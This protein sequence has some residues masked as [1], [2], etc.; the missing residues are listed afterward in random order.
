MNLLQKSRH[1]TQFIDYSHEFKYERFFESSPF[2]EAEYLYRDAQ[3][4]KI[5]DATLPQEKVIQT[6]GPFYFQDHLVGVF[7]YE[8]KVI[9]FSN[10]EEKTLFVVDKSKYEGYKVEMCTY[11]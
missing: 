11:Q 1:L 10:S 7:E 5:T 6:Y 4:T 3:T 2:G 9:V 8:Y